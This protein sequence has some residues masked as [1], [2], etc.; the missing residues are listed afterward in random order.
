MPEADSV[1]E[2]SLAAMRLLPARK[3]DTRHL[4]Q[5]I[6]PT[7]EPNSKDDLIAGTA[8]THTMPPDS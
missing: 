5:S 7:S 6:L 1:F 8:D 2:G 3:P 4:L